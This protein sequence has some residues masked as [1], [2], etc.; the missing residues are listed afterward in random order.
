MGVA[1]AQ[2]NKKHNFTRRSRD[3]WKEG[4]DLP[5]G[6]SSKEREG[7][8]IKIKKI[9][10]ELLYCESFFALSNYI[11]YKEYKLILFTKYKFN[12]FLFQL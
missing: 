4:P 7:T 9:K 11:L 8:V 1:S 5:V 6:W 10:T 3:G 12:T 2:N